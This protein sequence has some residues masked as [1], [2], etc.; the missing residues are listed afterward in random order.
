MLKRA[1]SLLTVKSFDPATRTFAGIATAP[2]PD[3]LGDTIQKVKFKNPLPLL[4]YHN[5]RMPVG[6]ARFKKAGPDGTP[7]DA[8]IS[9]IDRPGVVR[10]R[11]DE[12]VDSLA[13]DPPLIRGVSIGFRETEPPIYNKD[14]GGFDFPEVEVLELSMVVIPAHQDATIHTLKEYDTG[15]PASG[16]EDAVADI[17]PASRA[18]TRVITRSTGSRMAKKTYAEQ[19]EQWTNKRAAT[20]A[21]QDEIQT[22]ASDENRAKTPEEIESFKDLSEDVEACDREIADL[23][24]L[25][26]REKKAAIPV[27]GKTPERAAATRAGL[28]RVEPNREKGIG[29]ARL[30]MCVMKAKGNDLQAEAFAKQHYPD[31]SQLH[32]ALRV[33]GAIGAGA[34]LTSHWADDLVPYNV[35]QNE[36]IEFLRPGSILGKFGGPIPGTTGRNYPSLNKVPFNV[37][38]SGFS[39]GLTGYWVQEGLP[40]PVSKAVSFTAS[41]TW[42]K[43]GGLCIL[44]NEE[45]RFSNPNAEIKVRD[46]ISKAINART[47]IDFVDPAKVAVANV[48]PASITDGVAATAPSGT[49]ATNVRKDLA[50]LFATFATNNLEANDL[51]LIMSGTMAAQISMMV[52]TLGQ[53]D[54]PNLGL[55]GGLLR[56]IPVIVSEH[57][58]AVGSPSTQAIVLVKA[59]EIYLADDG[60]VTV[61]ASG[62]AS[63]EMLDSALQQSGIAG[64]G[65]SLVSLWQNG[66]L[67]LKGTREITWLRRRSTAVQYISPAAYVA[68]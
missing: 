14:T 26:A 33:K 29:F 58:T 25:E 42:A 3:R 43:V 12:A 24:A 36:F 54:F 34:A 22:K 63:I 11:L 13:A 59:S 5:S 27:D 18:S 60:A 46:E 52:N 8:K 68:A 45:V 55:Q 9:T 4:L 40:I 39:S 37:R 19:I 2:V 16:S 6:E 62:E 65:A 17:R 53:D 35:L 1:Y 20:V 32:A 64:T 15:L 56:G 23:K 10:D 47:D 61:D 30:A 21:A 50:T 28:V 38:T 49:A 48:S 67:G 7:F 51:V 41:L 31:D 66:L 44:T 57:L